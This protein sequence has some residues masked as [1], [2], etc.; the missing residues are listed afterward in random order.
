MVNDIRIKIENID[1][2]DSVL[3]IYGKILNEKYSN[4]FFEDEKENRYEVEYFDLKDGLFFK[5]CIDISNVKYIYPCVEINNE[6][7]FVDIDFSIS[8]KLNNIF[9]SLYIKSSSKIIKYNKKEKRFD[10]YKNTFINT[11]KFEFKCIYFLLKKKKFKNLLVR[12]WINISNYFKSREIW[13]ITDKYNNANDNGEEFFKYVINEQL[14][15]DTKYYFAID[16]KSKDFKRLHYNYSNVI[17]INSLRYKLLFLIA[18][19]IVSSRIDDININP[20]L[21]DKIYFGDLY[22]HK[23]VYLQHRNNI[24]KLV[25]NRFD[26]DMIITNNKDDYDYLSRNIVRNDIVKLTGFPRN[27]V[28]CN[29]SL[30]QILILFDEDE[31]E[32]NQFYNRLINDEKVISILRDRDYRIRLI[33]NSKND[34]DQNEY[35][36]IGNKDIVYNDEFRNSKLLITNNIDLAYDFSYSKKSVIYYS[37]EKENVDILGVSCFKYDVLV[38]EIIKL[39]KRDCVLDKKYNNKIDKLYEYNDNGNC[40][41]VYEEIIK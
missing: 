24:K 27:D 38:K 17:N 21:V 14:N 20:Y 29:N 35:V 1:V 10:V 22:N 12:E 4:L 36:S 23:Y 9:A 6:V 25:C 32:I 39:I 16:K 30:N 40:K 34:F 3:I 18:D 11:I 37:F 15:P 31:I 2:N 5:T 26:V 41:R 19:K 33:C 13:L 28:D 8:S 7:Y